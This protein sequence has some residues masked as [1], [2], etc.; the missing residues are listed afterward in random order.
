MPPLEKV[1]QEITWGVCVRLS[2]AGTPV[3]DVQLR[4]VASCQTASV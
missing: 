2:I 3:R 1:E 4:D